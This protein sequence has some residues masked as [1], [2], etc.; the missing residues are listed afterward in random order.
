MVEKFK[1]T[2]RRVFFDNFF[3]SVPLCEDLLSIGFTSVGTLRANKREIPDEFLVYKKKKLDVQ[4]EVDPDAMEKETDKIENNGM[5][6]HSSSEASTSRSKRT[7]KSDSKRSV[8]KTPMKAKDKILKDMK[9]P[10]VVLLYNQYKA[11]MDLTDRHTG[12]ESK[13]AK[14]LPIP[15]TEIFGVAG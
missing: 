8:T 6:E 15:K 4:R 5:N 11:G 14:G 13:L 12:D 2:G 10:R 9:K 7:P 3:T 1:E